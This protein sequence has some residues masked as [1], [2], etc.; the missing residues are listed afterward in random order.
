MQKLLQSLLDKLLRFISSASNALKVDFII[1]KP[2]RLLE[3]AR[4]INVL[5]DDG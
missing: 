4:K 1:K 3:L 2:F 5:F